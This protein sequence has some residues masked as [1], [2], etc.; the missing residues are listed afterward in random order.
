MSEDSSTESLLRRKYRRR[1]VRRF[2]TTTSL[3]LDYDRYDDNNDMSAMHSDSRDSSSSDMNQNRVY[4]SNTQQRRRQYDQNGGNIQNGGNS[5]NAAN[6]QYG[7]N[8]RSYESTRQYREQNDGY[9]NG[10]RYE[11]GYGTT[12]E[13]ENTYYSSKQVKKNKLLHILIHQ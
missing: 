9:S 12:K 10:R 3:P 4:T 7:A 2:R 1:K 6:G 11:Q 13:H 5:Q 8:S